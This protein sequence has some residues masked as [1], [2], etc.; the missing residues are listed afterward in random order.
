MHERTL[1]QSRAAELRARH[2]R[3]VYER[4]SIRRSGADLAVRFQFKLEPDVVFEP[5]LLFPDVDEERL[6]SLAPGVLENL[7][8]HIG[9]IETLSYW[10]CACP[11][12]LVV[13]AGPLTSDQIEWWRDLYRHGLGEF[14]YTNDVDFSAPDFVTIQS[15]G[16]DRFVPTVDSGPAAD[17]DFVLIGGG[18][19]SA[20]TLQLL[21][22]A[23]HQLNTLLLN[24]IES[25]LEVT[26]QAGYGEPVIVRRTIDPT[27]LRLNAASYLNG[28]TPFSAYLGFL[29]IAC[30]TLY[31]YRSLIVS[32]ERS[33]NEGNVEFH[34]LTVNHQY[35]KTFRFESSF[36]DYSR[37]YLST[38]AHYFS[39][40][41]PLYELQIAM[42]FATMPQYFPVC[43]SCNRNLKL[44]SWCGRCAKCLFVYTMLR[45]FLATSELVDIFGA[46]LFDREESIPLVAE[47]AGVSKHKP[48]DCV[49]TLAETQAALRLGVERVRAAGESLPTVLRWA[50]ESVLDERPESLSEAQALLRSWSPDHLLPEAHERLLRDRVRA[51]AAH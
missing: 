47:L 25:A 3:L 18:K 12:E 6:G 27:L 17:R 42:L 48:L 44:N 5:A 15:T 50:Q 16:A 35:S 20:V 19:D 43:K 10:K 21:K 7:I 37:R 23:G 28:H 30:A 34:G 22:D 8:F 24:P 51:L 32:N 38:R 46:D 40:L 14:Y 49:G 11:P 31:G 41:R 39:M 9:L 45:P 1:T 36:V 29:S 33:A 26:R 4:F 2:P 13:A